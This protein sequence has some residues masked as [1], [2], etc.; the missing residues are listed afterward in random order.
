MSVLICPES[1][2]IF[3]CRNSFFFITLM[4]IQNLSEAVTGIFATYPS[5]SRTEAEGMDRWSNFTGGSSSTRVSSVAPHGNTKAGARCDKRSRSR[6]KNERFWFH[7]AWISVHSVAGNCQEPPR[8][9][10]E[11]TM[12]CISILCEYGCRRFALN[13]SLVRLEVCLEA[14][15]C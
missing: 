12:T 8:A 4:R 13:F 15:C 10:K 6:G 14:P 9:T 1:G 3:L 5:C 7:N 11:M 2:R